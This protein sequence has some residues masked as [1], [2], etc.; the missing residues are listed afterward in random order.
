MHSP[1]LGARRCAGPCLTAFFV[2][3]LAGT[4]LADVRTY[5]GSGN[6]GLHSGW[7]AA[8][9][10][11]M[12]LA[13]PAYTDNHS[14]M[15]RSWV[16]S[17]RSISNAV[18]AQASSVTNNRGLSDMVWQW[19]QFLDHDL[20][21]T[22]A[23]GVE[24]APISTDPGDPHFLGTPIAFT[25]SVFDPAT[26]TSNA[27]EQP[28]VLSSYLDGSM[29]YGSDQ[30]KADGLRTNSGGRMRTSAHATGDMLPFNTT[31]LPN[32]NGPMGAPAA[33]MF[34]A[35]DIRANEQ[36][37]LTAMHTLWVREHNRVADAYAAANPGATDEDIFQAARRV[38]GAEIQA[39]TYNEWLPTLLGA[40]AVSEYQGY[41]ANVDATVSTE[42]SAAAFRIGHTMLSGTVRR[43]DNDGNTIP[44]GDLQLRDAFFNP[45]RILNEGGI[46]PLLK[47]LSSQ[48]AQ[49]IDTKIVDDVRN[50]LFGPPGS[51]GLDLASL[52]I[53]RGRDHGLCDYNTMRAQFGLG[54]VSSFDEINP[55]PNVW[56]ALATVYA[57][58][59]EIDPWV[60]MLAE[61][62][63][64]G[65]SVG[66]LMSAII[67]DQFERARDGDRFFFENDTELSSVLAWLGQDLDDIR[68]ISLG[69]IIRLNTDITNLQGNVFLVPSPGASVLAILSLAFI[70][71][72]RRRRA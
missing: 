38:V 7:G 15:A 69:D 46:D 58:V 66:A 13:P 60:G 43:V 68:G 51:G 54:A 25:R 17:P 24:S 48:L 23:G 22:P 8:N 33:S 37:G 19:G 12:R 31:G 4:A 34:V 29:I 1:L 40:G 44:E 11:L 42:F 72:P 2:A 3:A 45:N 9:G 59:N 18:N 53:Q 32:D 49:E 47:G 6:N 61:P 20:D 35:G 14:A 71:A 55:D 10:N 64:P 26:G 27:R 65:S 21:L 30:A 50:F 67:V 70:G 41:N 39:I 16:G 52:N 5:D 62:H 36:S 28:N 56:L 57:N 63:L